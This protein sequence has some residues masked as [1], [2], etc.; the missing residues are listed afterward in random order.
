M[1]NLDSII[2]SSYTILLY[3]ALIRSSGDWRS[4]LLPRHHHYFRFSCGSSSVCH[5]AAM[6]PG[7]ILLVGLVADRTPAATAD[8]G[9]VARV[10]RGGG[11]G[12]GKQ[13]PVAAS[14]VDQGGNAAR[15][16]CGGGDFCPQPR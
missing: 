6:D 16:C 9:A 1:G 8:P 7:S 12:E 4:L 13:I 3:T 10:G 14:A 11:G 2:K 5:A 15:V